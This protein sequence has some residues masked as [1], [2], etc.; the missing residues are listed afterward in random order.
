NDDVLKVIFNNIE[1]ENRPYESINALKK[2]MA[3]QIV[4]EKLLS[5]LP[6]KAASSSIV[7]SK[8]ANEALAELEGRISDTSYAQ[9]LLQRARREV[10]GTNTNMGIAKYFKY[11]S[12]RDY[13][14]LPSVEIAPA[15]L[16]IDYSTVSGLRQPRIRGSLPV[17]LEEIK[18]TRVFFPSA[19]VFVLSMEHNGSKAAVRLGFLEDGRPIA[20]KS[21]SFDPKDNDAKK[22]IEKYL[23]EEYQRA[24]IVDELGIGPA[25]HGFYE[26][27]TEL[28]FV[29]DIAT[30]DHPEA[31]T[32]FITTDTIIE[33]VEVIE[34][35]HKNG[36]EASVD[37]Q[38][39]V[40]PKGHV[41]IIDPDPLSIGENKSRAYGY[42][43]TQA[44]VDLLLLAEDKTQKE[45]LLRMLREK[46]DFFLALD[47][48]LEEDIK[49]YNLKPET[50]VYDLWQIIKEARRSVIESYGSAGS[51]LIDPEPAKELAGID[52]RSLP[53]VTQPV[54]NVPGAN[55]NTMPLSRGQINFD[56]AWQEIEHMLSAGIIPSTN[57]LKEKLE[58]SCQKD[59]FQQAKDKAISCIA[60]I[61]R[62]DEERVNAT[63][64]ALRQILVL[65]ESDKKAEEIRLALSK[66][67]IQE[68]EPVTIEP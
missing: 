45:A 25:L 27:P 5:A 37:F 34:R 7:A 21:Y 36:Y 12:E 29:M 26:T 41:Q 1:N 20:V 19:D 22:E 6:R 32:R 51:P 11:S 13:L 10:K 62:L 50:P 9:R 40:N 67:E 28:G 3:Y 66:I 39:L 16:P 53:V 63:E 30:G 8:N 42:G 43:D 23:L 55:L 49:R 54:I 33:L 48:S 65:L 18:R 14:F 47:A 56:K 52:L 44:L 15:D 2:S 35:L 17:S 31:I 60:D 68:K 57:R 38:Y 24:Q 61:L 4:K 59:E 46:P 58:D 64:A